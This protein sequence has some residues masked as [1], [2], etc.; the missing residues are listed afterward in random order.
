MPNRYSQGHSNFKRVA[1]HF[2]L[3]YSHLEYFRVFTCFKWGQNSHMTSLCVGW[4]GNTETIY[5]APE[6]KWSELKHIQTCFHMILWWL[7][8]FYTFYFVWIHTYGVTGVL[9]VISKFIPPFDWPNNIHPE[10]HNYVP[11]FT[12]ALEGGGISSPPPS[13]SQIIKKTTPNLEYCAEIENTP[14]VQILT[15]KFWLWQVN[16]LVTRSKVRSP[17]QVKARCALWNRLQ[18]C[19]I[20]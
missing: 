10:N 1:C 19:R 20:L 9:L 4:W 2:S 8:D 18:T 6:I 12:H 3:K 17:G 14:C 16:D 11:N 5:P 7:S 13:F 15:F